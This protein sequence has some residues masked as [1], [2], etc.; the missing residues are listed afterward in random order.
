MASRLSEQALGSIDK[1]DGEI[2]GAGASYHVACVLLMARGVGNNE[3]SFR[4]LEKTISNVNS[5]ALF[6]FGSETIHEQSIV[7]F[8][9]LCSVFF[10]VFFK[11]GDLV[12]TKFF[13]VKE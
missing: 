5:D 6:T 3:F 9:P 7:D 12:L 1:N 8:I 2:S 13:R 4:S 10:G 11:G